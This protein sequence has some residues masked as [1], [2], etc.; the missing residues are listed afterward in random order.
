MTI[1]R[2]I[3]LTVAILT[4]IFSSPV[5]GQT[6][7][8]FYDQ[9]KI[10][11]F[12][13][14]FKKIIDPLIKIELL[15]EGFQWTEGPVWVQKG[16]YLLFSDT[17]LNTIYKWSSK[18]GVEKFIQP[19]G[20]QG[21]EIYSEEPGTNGLV[22]NKEGYLVAC[23][24]GNRQIVQIDLNKRK[25]TP[26][27]THWKQLRFNSPNDICQHDH[28]D[29]FFTDPPYGLP[30]RE[31]DTIN[32]EII[33]NGVYR[34][35]SFG[36]AIQ[37]ISNLTRPNGIA[38]ST[39]QDKLYVSISD[40]Q[41]PFIMEYS[42]NNK[43]EVGKPEVFVDFKLKFPSEPMA[44]DGIKVHPDGYVFAAAGS[45]I[46]I[47]NDKGDVIGRIKL[48][49]ATANCNFGGDGYLYITASDKL[50]RVHLLKL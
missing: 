27:S 14:D 38:L 6:P 31:V 11:V 26:L 8:K 33:S 18:N 16:N 21:T 17:R 45:G 28:G 34:L 32:R 42:L 13:P 3:K 10:E 44:A 22:I 23:D 29:Y 15:A 25:F 39:K 43:L 19:A 7:S 37:I 35:D 40:H 24:H 46:I 48:G 5:F 30:N 41:H 2:N 20:Y 49:I 9:A 12:H 47:L 50:L 4:I 36:N 1:H